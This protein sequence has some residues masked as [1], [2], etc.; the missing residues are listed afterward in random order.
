MDDDDDTNKIKVSMYG[1]LLESLFCE[2]EKKTLVN[3]NT[4]L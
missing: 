1:Y 2:K 3:V 4:F